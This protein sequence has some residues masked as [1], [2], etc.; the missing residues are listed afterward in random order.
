MDYFD[1]QASAYPDPSQV[2]EVITVTRR[3]GGV[4][5]GGEDAGEAASAIQSPYRPCTSYLG[6]DLDPFCVRTLLPG[7]HGSMTSTG[8]TDLEDI[9]VADALIGNPG[10]KP[11]RTVSFRSW[12]CSR[13]LLRTGV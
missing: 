11:E 1:P 13:N 12:V 3:D 7:T 2:I 5:G 8:M 6:Q 4:S 10:L 9:L